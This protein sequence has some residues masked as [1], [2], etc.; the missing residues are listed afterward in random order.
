MT[1]LFKPT[2]QPESIFNPIHRSQ[3]IHSF[4]TGGQPRVAH[5]LWMKFCEK[6]P[7]SLVSEIHR[8]IKCE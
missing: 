1:S 7:F 3:D 6:R 5:S 4:S 2:H 8:E